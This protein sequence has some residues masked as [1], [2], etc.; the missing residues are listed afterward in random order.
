[1]GYWIKHPDWIDDP[2]RVLKLREETK[3][4]AEDYITKEIDFMPIIGLVT[5]KNKPY[6]RFLLPKLKYKEAKTIHR[7]GFEDIKPEIIR[8]KTDIFSRIQ[9]ILDTDYLINKTVVIVGLGTGGSIG[10]IEL[11]KCGVG[12][13]KLIDFDR[14]ETHNISRH[15]C[16]LEDIGRLKTHAVKDAILRKNPLA[17]VETYEFNVLEDEDKFRNIIKGADL[18]FVATDNELSKLM[19]NR[20]CWEE[21]IPSIYG[22][23]YER[24]FGG[25]VIRVIPE[26][27]PCYDCVMGKLIRTLD[28]SQQRKGVIDYTS[29]SDPSQ[30]KAEPGLSVDVGFIALIQ[31]K[32]ALLTLLRNSKSE[33]KDIPYNMCFWGNRDEWIF[34]EPFQ[35]RFAVTEVREDCET[36]KVEEYY[37]RELGEPKSELQKIAEKIVKDASQI[38][39]NLR[40]KLKR[41][42]GE[43][44]HGDVKD[45][46]SSRVD[47]PSSQDEPIE[48]VRERHYLWYNDKARLRREYNEMKARFPDFEIYNVGDG[49]IA[50]KGNYKMSEDL[51][52]KIAIVYPYYFP[53]EP[54]KV[55]ILEPEIDPTEL[56]EDGSIPVFSIPDKKW[57][58]TMS[59]KDI[60]I[61]AIEWLHRKARIERG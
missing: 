50:W 27:T 56:E 47:E 59:A 46:E 60:L 40:N 36:C 24:A 8:F 45:R 38:S 7:M 52:Y 61:W 30:L 13:F 25:D 4:L 12:H 39:Q 21:K 26:E 57:K 22:A 11:A 29:I 58:T 34:S 31:V 33:L 5:N 44:Q 23:A 35:C 3:W 42:F 16:G 1:V 53:S 19:I 6:I 17:I 15:V 18:V 14:L 32:F 37:K 49:K 51:I 48:T 20:V 54:P 55:Y 43:R 10:A 28:F 2:K 41:L 9:G